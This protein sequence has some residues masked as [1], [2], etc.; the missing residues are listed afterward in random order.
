MG[1][2][3]SEALCNKVSNVYKDRSK[4]SKERQNIKKMSPSLRDQ[5]KPPGL[6]FCFLFVARSLLFV[7]FVCVS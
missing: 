4:S 2:D 1:V 7:L 5:A 6:H 3:D